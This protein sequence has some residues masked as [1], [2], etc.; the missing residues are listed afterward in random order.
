MS[1]LMSFW[2]FLLFIIAWNFSFSQNVRSITRFETAAVSYYQPQDQYLFLGDIN[3]EQS[4]LYNRRYN[5]TDKEVE[6]YFYQS[7]YFKDSVAGFKYLGFEF[8][9][10]REPF[11]D[12]PGLNYFRKWNRIRI[13]GAL[14]VEYNPHKAFPDDYFDY[15]NGDIFIKFFHIRKSARGDRTTK[16]T[17]GSWGFYADGEFLGRVYI[18]AYYKAFSYLWIHTRYKKESITN[19]KKIAIILEF[20]LNKYGYKKNK[21]EFT[22]DTY[23]GITLFVGPEYNANKL[24]YSINLG[25]KMDF[26]NH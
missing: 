14:S 25:F 23:N 2:L 17:R 19:D 18:D 26:R 13:G 6:S 3:F 8:N 24:S 11:E 12:S 4:L 5:S 1:R 16:S 9:L 7:I 15:L 21:V 20:E 10:L 22:K